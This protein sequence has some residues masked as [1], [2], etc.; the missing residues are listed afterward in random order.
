M[1]EDYK[2]N[3]FKYL[4]GNLEE[5]TGNNEPVYQTN[6]K[7]SSNLYND[8]HSYYSSIIIYTGFIPS[9]NNENQ[10]QNYSVISC[11]GTLIGE[12]DTTG[13]LAIIDNNCNLVQLITHY[14][15]GEIIGNINCLNVD[16]N[17]NYCLVE[18]KNNNYRIVL[19]NNIV[20]KPINSN[21][22]Q[23]VKIETYSIPNQYT[24]DKFS[25]I[26]KENNNYFLLGNR[27]NSEGGVGCEYKLGNNSWTYYTTTYQFPV[28]AFA[29]ISN[30]FNVY[31]DTNNDLQFQLAV[32]YFGLII[33][34][35]GSSTT[36]TETR[37]TNSD[38]SA[39]N[40][41]CVFYSNKIAYYLELIDN[42]PVMFYNIYKIDL[43]NN[44]SGLIATD[45][46]D[47]TAY[48]FHSKMYFI[49]KDNL[50]FYYRSY[51]TSGDTNYNVYLGAI[52]GT[53]VY[54]ETLSPMIAD[55]TIEA[56]LYANV[57]SNYNQVYIN[58][59]NRTSLY[60]LSL[61]WNL[62]NYNGLSFISTGS[63]IP[64]R[65]TLEDEN[66]NELFNRNIFNL[67]NYANWY[68]ASALVPNFYLNNMQISNANLYSTNN[69]LLVG[70]PINIT[71]NV[72]E[73]LNINF[74]NKFNILDNENL[75]LNASIQFVSNMLSQTKT[76]YIGKY[77]INYND[78]TSEIKY[79]STKDLVYTSLDIG[80]KTTLKFSFYTSKKIDTIDLMSYDETITYKT[81]NCSNLDLNK[82]YL[83]TQDIRIE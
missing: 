77:K 80:M 49:K 27:A 79:L 70:N 43:E 54:E 20:L 81:F 75:Q 82:Y 37:Y 36:M 48:N 15:D 26:F 35:K 69:N 6:T 31:W 63:L 8:I 29:T 18:Y 16:E 52:N 44:S 9:K 17:G 42:D 33:L 13:A 32:N 55:G 71:K 7:T 53:N 51:C 21:N 58:M 83:I 34:S 25:A 57:I 64:N 30:G 65:I 14:S 24:W 22:Y 50:I 41:D 46:N 73:E 59:V 5:Q 10:S 1:T 11:V 4:T 78:S 3:V 76:T 67:T 45:L 40:T 56:L 47:K 66:E 68:T 28:A 12:S 23:A 19:L 72:Y 38:Y 61:S 39:I 2:E 60:Q 74:I 62:N